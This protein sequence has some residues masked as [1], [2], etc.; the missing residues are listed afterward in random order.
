MN[1]YPRIFSF[2]QC[3]DSTAASDCGC[4]LRVP[5][6]PIHRQCNIWNCLVLHVVNQMSEMVRAFLS[7]DIE[8]QSVIQQISETQNMLDTNLAKMKLVE[9]ENIH[10]TLRFLG[11]TPP[12]KIDEVE[13]SLSQIKLDPFD[14][15]VHGVGAFPNNRRPR[16]IW[17]GVTQNADRIQNLKAEID[18]RLKGLGF[19]PEKK[20]FTP[21]ATIAQ[22]RFIK[23]AEGLSRNLG[24]IMNKPI[25]TMTVSRFNMKKSTLTPSGAIYET[26]WHVP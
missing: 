9:I 23:D 10:F 25:G 16:V 18:S 11:D 21:H 26:L 7:I 22:V 1:F 15:A 13:S 6:E 12:A 20:R 17:I 2:R 19:H 4:P 14:I 3:S 8:N 5:L 24:E